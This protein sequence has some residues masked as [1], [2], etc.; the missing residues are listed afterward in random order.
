MLLHLQ[1]LYFIFHIIGTVPGENRGTAQIMLLHLQTLY[2]IF[3]IIGTAR[4]KI[5]ERKNA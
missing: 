1:T 2:F 4:P 3:H 5:G